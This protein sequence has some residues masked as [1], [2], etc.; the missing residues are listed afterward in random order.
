M[1]RAEVIP[2]PRRMRDGSPD[3]I[4]EHHLIEPL[5]GPSHVPNYAQK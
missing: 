1:L 4:I 2:G 5:R 3:A